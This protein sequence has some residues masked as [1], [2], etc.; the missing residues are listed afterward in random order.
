LGDFRF[1]RAGRQFE[2]GGDGGEA[3]VAVKAGQKLALSGA[4]FKRLGFGGKVLTHSYAL[5]TR[6]ATIGRLARRRDCFKL[7][8]WG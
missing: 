6:N 5:K 8:A 4:L 2:F 1:E 3:D 7:N